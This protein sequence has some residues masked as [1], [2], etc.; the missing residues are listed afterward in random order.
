MQ[1]RDIIAPAA[2]KC[3][4]GPAYP[5]RWSRSTCWRGPRGWIHYRSG[6]VGTEKAPCYGQEIGEW[7]LEG[8]ISDYC[9]R[10]WG[11]GRHGMVK[12]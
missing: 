4:L 12:Q 5:L 1:R 2:S 7:C 3:T 8:A 10:E 9:I 11:S 6:D